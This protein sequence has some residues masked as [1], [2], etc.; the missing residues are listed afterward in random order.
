MTVT[1]RSPGTAAANVAAMVPPAAVM[2]V[3]QGLVAPQP[4]PVQP[5]KVALLE[6]EAVRVTLVPAE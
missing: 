6:G 2:T 3:V 5:V 1:T 4:P